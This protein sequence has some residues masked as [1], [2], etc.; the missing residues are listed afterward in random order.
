MDEPRRLS[1]EEVA[2]ILEASGVRALTPES[3]Y[4]EI[5][6]ALV[7]CRRMVRFAYPHDIALVYAGVIDAFDVAR[8]NTPWVMED[9]FFDD[10]NLELHSVEHNVEGLRT[11]GSEMAPSHGIDGREEHSGEQGGERGG[12]SRRVEIVVPGRREREGGTD[13]EADRAGEV[14]GEPESVEGT[15]R[16]RRSS[17]LPF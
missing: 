7:F 8:L 2:R 17:K 5:M 9:I 11:T 14:Q 3:N 6:R 10:I 4:G 13:N 15:V 1:R 12:R 16:S